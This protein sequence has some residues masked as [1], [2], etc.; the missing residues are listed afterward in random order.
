MSDIHALPRIE[1]RDGFRTGVAAVDHEHRQLVDILNGILDRLEAGG[2]ADETVAYLGEVYARISAHFALEEQVMREKDYDD[3]G[4][5]KDDHESLL[6][7][8][9]DLMD[10]FEDGTYSGRAGAFA[11]RLIGWFTDHFATRDARLHRRLGE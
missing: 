3:Y 6:D 8:I 10:A 7:D 2:D 5:H 11:E 1:W 9:R 4:G